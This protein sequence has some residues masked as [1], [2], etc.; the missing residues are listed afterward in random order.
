MGPGEAGPEVVGPGTAGGGTGIGG[1]GKTGSGT[2][3]NASP[4]ATTFVLDVSGSMSNPWRGGIKLESAK[5]AAREVLD[6]IR[7]DVEA[8]SENEVALVTFSDDSNVIRAPTS[9]LDNVDLAIDGLDTESATN[10]GAGFATGLDTL[11]QSQPGSKKSLLLLTDGMSNLGL[12]DEAILS[13]P[14]REAAS[15][16]VCVYVL[17]VG[18]AGEIDEAFLQ[19]LGATS[20][21]GGYYP[22]TNALGIRADFHRAFL[23]ISGTEQANFTGTVREGE[24]LE[25]GS[26][27]VPAGQREL[28]AALIWPGSSL[29]LN[30]VDPTGRAVDERYKGARFDVTSN[31]VSLS[32]ANPRRGTWRLGLTGVDVPEGTTEYRALTSV[33]PAFASPSEGQTALVVVILTA[34]LGF[35]A[36]G[37]V[38]LRPD[39]SSWILV[40]ADGRSVPL[41]KGR[42][43]V[44][45]GPEARVRFNDPTVS[46]RHAEIRLDGNQPRV[47]DL[48]SPNGTFRN[49]RRIATASLSDGDQLGFG[50][51]TVGVRSKD[52]SGA[53]GPQDKRVPRARRSGRAPDEA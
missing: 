42:N 39:G 40:L 1:T 32:L 50:R 27:E 22:V 21:C 19:H 52:R 33:R 35:F 31:R 15:L 26:F 49:G 14:A 12:D 7:S 11:R 45:R 38:F 24:T 36:V 28:V 41:R 8:G 53:A 6:Q 3:G 20:N 13:G 4:L 48:Q 51:A 18:N 16:G 37:F 34:A 47:S 17:G 25:A 5:L 9:D 29:Q 23:A 2:T 10:I 44:G 46:K 30:L 43:L